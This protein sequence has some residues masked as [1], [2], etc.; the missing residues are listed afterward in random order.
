[1]RLAKCTVT[2]SQLET[3][4]KM[5]RW[6]GVVHAIEGGELGFEGELATEVLQANVDK[7]SVESVKSG[8]LLKGLEY[9]G[10]AAQLNLSPASTGEWTY[11]HLGI[12][13]LGNF[14]YELGYGQEEVNVFQVNVS[15]IDGKRINVSKAPKTWKELV[16]PGINNDVR[17]IVRKLVDVDYDMG[18]AS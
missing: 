2:A 11:L 6:P 10:H 1:M 3:G 8:L 13:T 15:W 17:L 7:I 14:Y 16:P 4:D 9:K 12:E 18:Q 5:A